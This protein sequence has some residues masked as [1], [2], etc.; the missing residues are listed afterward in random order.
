MMEY[1]TVLV[2]GDI[3]RSPRMQYHAMSLARQAGLNVALVGY[4]GSEPSTDLTACPNVTLYVLPQWGW[5]PRSR[6]LFLAALPF[7]IAFQ[8]T[9]LLLTLLVRVPRPRYILVQNPPAIPSLIIAKVVALLQSASLI[10]DW[11]NFGYSILAMRL[12]RSHPLVT[13]SYW[14]ERLLGRMSDDNFCVTRAMQQ[15]LRNVWSIDARVLHDR[16]PRRFRRLSLPEIHNFFREL[17]EAGALVGLDDWRPSD[18]KR[19]ETLITEVV[20]GDIQYRKDRPAIIISS[21]SYT[22]DED[23]GILLDA[24]VAYDR[25]A[26]DNAARLL[27]VITGKGPL[28]QFYADAIAKL[29][30]KRTRF[31]QLWM[32]ADDYPKMLGCA[33]LGVSL[34]TS[35]SGLDL[36]MKVVDMF[37]CGLPVC[38]VGFPCLDELLQHDHN[39]MVFGSS[40][41]LKTQLQGL[42]HNFP[43]N[44]ARLGTLRSNVAS[45]TSI[46]WDDCWRENALPCFANARRTSKWPALGLGAAFFVV[47][48][49]VSFLYRFGK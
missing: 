3:G 34:H 1:V 5:R 9:V 19:E 48:L 23:F 37:G 8:C 26:S 49:L 38:A 18:L 46:R 43:S 42:F 32:A 13:I 7:R 21:T 17:Q 4:A 10:V 35:S 36:P 29:S 39:G 30:L 15:E 28:K 33:D 40:E 14:Y 45:F 44:T 12:G 20:D 25:E 27:F 41:E 24:A 31:L 16:P 6:L 47:V 22:A 11:H 2:L